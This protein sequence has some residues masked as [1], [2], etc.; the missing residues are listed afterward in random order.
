[1]FLKGFVLGDEYKNGTLDNKQPWENRTLTI[2]EINEDVKQKL[3][4]QVFVKI[5]LADPVT[6]DIKQGA[7]L[8]G[9]FVELGITDLKQ[10]DRNKRI[11]FTGSVLKVTGKMQE[12]PF[13]APK[14]QEGAKA[15]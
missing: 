1:M 4:P 11:V 10:D 15:A 8:Y 9:T 14:G 6:G 3:V 5:P 13:S 2:V 12:V 7:T